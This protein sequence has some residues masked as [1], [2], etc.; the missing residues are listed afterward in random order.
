M[1]KVGD[2][3]KDI[4]TGYT[5]IAVARTEW[6]NGCIRFTV[7]SNEYHDS[8][9]VDS[10]CVDEPQLVIVEKGV[11]KRLGDECI[12]PPTSSQEATAPGGPAPTPERH[13]DPTR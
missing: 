6:L 4:V 12:E 8:K 7:Q 11:T 10:L 13:K 3:V 2:R 1:I 9:P 5:G